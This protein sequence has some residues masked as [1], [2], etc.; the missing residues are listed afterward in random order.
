MEQQP[1]PEDRGE[2][3]KQLMRL[4]SSAIDRGELQAATRFLR[5]AANLGESEKRESAV[6]DTLI[7]TNT[8]QHPLNG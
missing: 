2:A 4:A 1:L 3:V 6:L 8:A 5:L 7:E